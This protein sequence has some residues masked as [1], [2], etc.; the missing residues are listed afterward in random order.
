MATTGNLPAPGAVAI[1]P[2]KEYVPPPPPSE[3]EQPWIIESKPREYA[4]NYTAKLP[5]FIC[6]QVTHRY[7]DPTGRESWRKEDEILERLSYY[8]HH[9]DYKVVMRNNQ[10]VSISHDK[11]GGSVTSSG[12]FGSIMDGVFEPRTDTE[13]KWARLTTW[14]RRLTYVFSYHVEK[15]RSNYHMTVALD[16]KSTDNVSATP[17]YHG[18]VFIDKQNLTVMKLT[19]ETEDLPAD[20][21]V[22]QAK[23][24]LTYDKTKIGEYEFVLPHQAVLTSRGTANYLTKN[25]IDFVMYRKFG[26]DTDIKFDTPEPL[27]EKKEQ[28]AK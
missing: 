10:P 23:L 1:A 12:E 18:E 4:L 15:G 21:P 8:E 9:E 19:L 28:P 2:K 11:L 13:F 3:E 24:V 7:S 22:K 25:N 27:P 20:F 6:N 16:P 14:D 5:D 26:A 17:A